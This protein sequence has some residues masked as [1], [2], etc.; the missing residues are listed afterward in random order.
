MHF[1]S[2]DTRIFLIL[3]FIIEKMVSSLIFSVL[4]ISIYEDHFNNSFINLMTFEMRHAEYSET[5]QKMK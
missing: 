3:V 5:F 2:I 4:Y 1:E